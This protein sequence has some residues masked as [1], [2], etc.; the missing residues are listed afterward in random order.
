MTI[1]L[2]TCALIWWSLDPEK[3]SADATLAC[4]EMELEKSGLVPSIVI[5][6]IALKVKNK[7]LD[8][9]IHLEE[10]LSALKKSDVIRIVAIDEDMWFKSV[11]LDW[12]HR[13]PVDRVVVALAKSYRASIITS[14]REIRDYYSEVLW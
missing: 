9:G 6:E 8:L 13:D 11:Q 10:Y 4:H 12:S 5:W 14:D 7:K 2:D 1:I 3:L